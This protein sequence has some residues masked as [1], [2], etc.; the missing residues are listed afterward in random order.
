[1]DPAPSSRRCALIDFLMF[2]LELVDPA[3][4]WMPSF[5]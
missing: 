3:T 2:I 5:A 4:T 1:M